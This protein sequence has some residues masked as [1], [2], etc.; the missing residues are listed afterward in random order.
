MTVKWNGEF[1]KACLIFSPITGE[2]WEKF[3]EHIEENGQQ[4]PIELLPDGTLLDGRNRLNACRQLGIEPKFVEVNPSSPVEYVIGNNL[5]LRELNIGEKA[6]LALQLI[7]L[8]AV[9]AAER[10]GGRPKK[11]EKNLAS[12]DAKIP[13]DQKS[14][15][16]AAK[17]VGVSAKTVE[18]AKR[19]ADDPRPEAK[20]VLEDV[21]EGKTTLKVAEQNLFP[22]TSR[23][24]SQSKPKK[25]PLLKGDEF[26][27]EFTKSNTLENLVRSAKQEGFSLTGDERE[28][29]LRIIGLW[30]EYLDQLEMAI[31]M[32]NVDWDDM[33]KDQ[34]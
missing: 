33:L 14:T 17:S 21:K 29:C 31:N 3:V 20:Q 26:V 30:R 11:G 32:T 9:E 27:H 24:P 5:R 22:T 34:R 2:S 8:L 6:V 1:H 12:Q 4:H 15:A 23:R 18:R 7:P 10:K 19:I 13:E 28:G 16:K 25:N